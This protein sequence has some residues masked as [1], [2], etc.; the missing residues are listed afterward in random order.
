VS[1]IARVI[2]GLSIGL[3]VIGAWL[4]LAYASDM[5]R[6]YEGIEGRSEVVPSPFGDIE[7]CSGGSG[8]PVLVVHGSGG[9]FDQG[10]L[11]AEALLDDGYRWIAP[12]RFGYLRSTFRQ[13]AT[14]DDQADAYAWLLDELGIARVAVVALS[15]GGPSALLF[16]A[17]HPER[18]SALVLLSAG[19]ASI[20]GGTDDATQVEA[21]RRGRQLVTVFRHDPLYWFASRFLRRALVGLMGAGGVVIEGLA[22]EQIAL[23]DRVI[24]GM[25]PVAPRADGVVFDHRAALPGARISAIRAPTLVVHARDDGLQSFRNAEFALQHIPG[26]SALVFDRGGHLVLA[27]ELD[28]IGAAVREH[29]GAAV[30]R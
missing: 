8:A 13:G 6:A 18:V 27:T 30:A 5:R 17:R 7:Y 1:V 2:L 9:G 14:F 26:A 15:H 12:S 23:I 20:D 21:D 11:V 4:V 28:A 24:D 22:A 3:G 19:V 29:L 16:A 25:N 10:E